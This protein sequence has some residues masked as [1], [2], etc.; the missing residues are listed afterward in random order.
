MVRQE[1]RS[2]C[3][4]NDELERCIVVLR[5]PTLKPAKVSVMPVRLKSDEVT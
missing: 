4:L 1:E 2:F 3:H 5:T